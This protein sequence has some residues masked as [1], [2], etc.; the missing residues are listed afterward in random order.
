M[1][2]ITPRYFIGY[3][4][5]WWAVWAIAAIVGYVGSGYVVR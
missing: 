3:W 2:R 5:W 4:G 1:T